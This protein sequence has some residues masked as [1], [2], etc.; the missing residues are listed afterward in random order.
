MTD[1]S[2]RTFIKATSGAIVAGATM[3]S[4]PTLSASPRRLPIGIQLYTVRELLA[5]DF[6]GTLHELAAAG[7]EEVESAGYYGRTARDF[8][9]AV[10]SA[11]L[12]CVS[13]HHPLAAL[14]PKPEE[15][16]QYGHDLGIEY[17]ICSSP[18]PKNPEQKQLTLDDWKWNA[19]QFNRIAEKAKASGIKFGYH[20][21][22]RELQNIDGK[23]PY[24]ELLRLTDAS[25]VKMEMDCGWF[26]VGG[27]QPT[28]YLTK[29]PE[30]FTLLHVKDVI[31]DKAILEASRSTELG[32]GSIDYA[33]IFA[34]A[35]SLEHYFVEQEEFDI[36]EL[37]AIKIDAEYVR[38][39]KI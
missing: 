38:K 33:P 14:L 8:R 1:I 6:D 32:R 36:P 34:A 39:M 19:D 16:I 3:S 17:L 5:K 24:D 21:H 23:V 4:L 28:Q 2:R 7:Y 26:V 29:Y 10:E 12:K 31:V 9:K 20:N 25:L 30:R 18:A 13:A 11:G 27:L 37:E 22:V 15:L 35:K